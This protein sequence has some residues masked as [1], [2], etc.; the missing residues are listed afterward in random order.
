MDFTVAN[1]SIVGAVAA[2]AISFLSPC[3]LPLI[4]GY[5]SFVAGS[6]GTGAAAASKLRTA[7]L[8]LCFILGFATIF[9][10]L[11]AGATVL[12]RFLRTWS[13]EANIIGGSLV[14]FFG[15]AT[16]GLVQMPW[17]ERDVRFHGN[18]AVNGPFGAYLLGLAFAFGWTPCIGPILGAILTVGAVSATASDGVILL[19]LYSLGL[20]I[21]FFLSAMFTQSLLGTMREMRTAGR[22]LKIGSGFVMVAMGLAM[23][24][25][26]L[27]W[28]AFWLLT[29]FPILGRI[30]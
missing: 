23:M 29:N 15:I 11:G 21:P 16:T 26:T 24:T 12:S 1:I 4:P 25:G 17:M 27:N 8:S 14:L 6:S 13:F 7:I 2:G 20:G 18:L 9:V 5:V 3:V 22:I 19:A 28:A 30:G 10:A